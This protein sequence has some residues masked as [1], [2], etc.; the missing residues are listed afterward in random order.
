[1]KTAFWKTSPCLK[2]TAIVSLAVACLLLTPSGMCGPIYDGLSVNETESLAKIRVAG[3]R[4]DRSQIPDIIATLN[5]P[6]HGVFM[7]AAMQAL[8]RMGATEGLDAVEKRIPASLTPKQLSM[9]DPRAI[10]VINYARVAR[11]RLLAESAA[12][13]IVGKDAQAAAKIARFYAEL[14]LTPADLNAAVPPLDQKP[15]LGFINTPL[16]VY[17]MREIADMV[18]HGSYASFAALPGV[19]QVHFSQYGPAALKMRLA[20]LSQSQRMNTMIE[21]L[22]KTSIETSDEPYETQLLADEGFPATQAV[23]AKLHEIDKRRDEYSSHGFAAL[24]NVLRGI[25]DQGQT[26]L[27]SQFQHDTDGVVANYANQVYYD[28]RDGRRFVFKADY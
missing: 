20:A 5:K 21:E 7:T 3:L 28:V 8:A 26:G 6:P 10:E 12:K 23:A 11:A 17:A 22:A 13:P 1:M 16:E 4:Q 9:T 2:A 19:A 25:G 24:F 15:A 27:I 18:Y 14:K